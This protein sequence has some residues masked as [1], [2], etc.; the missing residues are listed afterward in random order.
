MK[1]ISTHI[2]Q[3]FA[4]LAVSSA[5][6]FTA[7]AQVKKPI[8]AVPFT[9]TKPG[10]YYLSKDLVVTKPHPVLGYT[11]IIVA[12]DNVSIDLNGRQLSTT[13]G[14]GTGINSKSGVSNVN[15]RNGVVRGFGIGIS[16]G[17]KP[18]ALIEDVRVLN[19]TV[20]GIWLTMDHATVRR[21]V[22]RD[23]GGKGTSGI[24][25]GIRIDRD[26][27][28]VEDCTVTG[29]TRDQPTLAVTAIHVD[30]YS[31]VSRNMIS[32]ALGAAALTTGIH[33]AAYNEIDG[34]LVE[35]FASGVEIQIGVYRSNSTFVCT[36]KYTGGMDG[37]GNK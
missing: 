14:T 36:T 30:S 6:T 20:I 19:C 22:V 5:F 33:S 23:T 2:T 12:S 13:T 1:N 4:I 17:D 7:S 16:L 34:N 10:N 11:G 15:V 24:V 3:I 26:F 28:V 21:C 9:I 35:S 29:F 32:S 8:N 18:H 37:G 27:A 31:R 25:Q